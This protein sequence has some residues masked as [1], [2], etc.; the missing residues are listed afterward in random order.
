MDSPEDQTQ[1]FIVRVWLERK[2][3]GRHGAVWRGHVTHVLTGDRRYV[4]DLGGITDFIASYL[5]PSADAPRTDRRV[6]P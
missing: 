5:P 3:H 6:S 4:A 1:S 2:A